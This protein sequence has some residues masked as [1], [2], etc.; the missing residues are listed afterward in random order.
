MLENKESSENNKT[1][2]V[3]AVDP[4]FVN[5]GYIIVD[6]IGQPTQFTVKLIANGVVSTEKSDK[7]RGIRASDD[8]V[9]RCLEWLSAFDALWQEFKPQMS[10]YE[11]P[12]AGGK[13]SSAVKSM[14][15]ATALCSSLSYHS[16]SPSEFFTPNEVK[17]ALAKNITASKTDMEKEAIKMFPCLQ[18]KY[19]SA[20]AATGFTGEFE[21]VADAVGVLKA[22]LQQGS[23]IKVFLTK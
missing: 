12:S 7:K 4:A 6:I 8:T 14:A 15:I 2:R 19:S 9:R 18:E 16:N 1:V 20:R 11:L 17:S 10:A 5:T 3:L 13:S 22:C 21:H 23:L